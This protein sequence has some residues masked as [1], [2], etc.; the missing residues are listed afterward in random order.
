MSKYIDMEVKADVKIDK[1]AQSTLQ[2]KNTGV[3]ITPGMSG[4]GSSG[5][6]YTPTGNWEYNNGSEWLTLQSATPIHLTQV[7]NITSSDLVNGVATIQHKFGK[8]P[9]GVD[10]SVVPKAITYVDENTIT[11]DFSDQSESFTGASVWFIGS[12]QSMLNVPKKNYYGSDNGTFVWTATGTANHTWVYTKQDD[13]SALGGCY[14]I[15]SDNEYVSM[16]A[17][18]QNSASSTGYYIYQHTQ[19]D[20][21]GFR[22]EIKHLSDVDKFVVDNLDWKYVTFSES[23]YGKLDVKYVVGS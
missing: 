14:Y 1:I 7:I 20:D 12:Q 15:N 16:I 22:A 2:L 19:D 8:V 3:T 13:T 4:I 11:L 10:C 18:E 5:F 21:I 17:I 23:K 6:R 9:F